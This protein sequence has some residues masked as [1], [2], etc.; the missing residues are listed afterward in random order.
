MCTLSNPRPKNFCSKNQFADCE[1]SRNSV[2]LTKCLGKGNFGEVY[3]G[4]HRSVAVAV[5]KGLCKASKRDM[6]D[7][8]NIMYQLYH[9]RLVRLLGVCCE[10]ATE[11]IWLITEFMPKGCLYDFLMTEEGRGLSI[12]KIESILIE[13]KYFLYQLNSFKLFLTLAI[14][15]HL[16]T[17]WNAS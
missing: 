2:K 14:C 16:Q 3:L 11:P 12:K 9:P 15:F 5:K 4:E 13:V 10:P 1:V 6:L 17:I 8:A 7:E